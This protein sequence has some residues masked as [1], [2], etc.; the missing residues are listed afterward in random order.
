MMCKPKDDLRKDCRLMEFNCLINKVS[1]R[2][3]KSAAVEPYCVLQC[4][5]ITPVINKVSG[6][7]LFTMCVVPP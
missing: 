5:Y 3:M 2:I 6:S 7:T 1:D 4:P